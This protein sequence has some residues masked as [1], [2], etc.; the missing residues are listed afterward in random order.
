MSTPF[1]HLSYDGHGVND[2]DKYRSRLATFADG[3]YQDDRDRLGPMFAA[4]PD[5]LAALV[6]LVNR[7][8]TTMLAD[9]SSLDTLAAHAAIARAHGLPLATDPE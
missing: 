9:G 7:A 4:A 2:T 8:D 5:L 1:R 6:D 3:V